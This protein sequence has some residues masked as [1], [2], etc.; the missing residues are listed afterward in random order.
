MKEKPTSKDIS[1]MSRLWKT[2]KFQELETT[3]K[4]K[5]SAFDHFGLW[6]FNRRVR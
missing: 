6:Q 2:F 1:Q 3:V 4:H 5:N